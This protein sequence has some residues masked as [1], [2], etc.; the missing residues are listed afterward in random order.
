MT[1]T[2][3]SL[4]SIAIGGIA[5]LVVGVIIGVI[6]GFVVA[7]ARGTNVDIS[8]LKA[9][10][11][12][13]YIVLVSAAFA[14]DNDLGVAQQRL[15]QLNDKDIKAHVTRLAKSYATQDPD[16]AA[17]LAALSLALGSNDSVLRTL[18]Q[19][20]TAPGGSTAGG[21]PTKFAQVPPTSTSTPT[22]TPAPT[23]TPVPTNTAAP[24]VVAKP[25]TAPKPPTAPVVAAAAAAIPVDWRPAFPGQWWR[26]IRYTPANASAGQT[27]WRLKSAL[28]CDVNDNRNSCPDLTGGNNSHDIYISLFDQAGKCV[29]G[30]IHHVINDGTEPAVEKKDE[31]FPWN[32]CN[33]D[34]QWNMYGEGNTFWV[35]GAPSD[36]I[37]NLCMCSVSDNLSNRMHVRYYLIFQLTTR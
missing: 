13:G 9:D 37:E 11:Q 25:T 17:R 31:P 35:D 16:K 18:A 12:D 4:V 10:S 32:Q 20:L 36:K 26:D 29:T 21:A 28:Y 1:E 24:V 14:Y 7:P 3:F 27:Y 34:Y 23:K 30:N 2:R 6:I 19:S 5:G 33:F 8:D 15:A 22:D